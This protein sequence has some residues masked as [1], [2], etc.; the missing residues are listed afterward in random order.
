MSRITRYKQ[1]DLKNILGKRIFTNFGSR[2]TDV[3]EMHVYG[4]KTLIDSEYN[5]RYQLQA[6]DNIQTPHI[7]MDI[8]NQ[9]RNFGYTKGR[10][11]VVYNFFRNIIGEYDYP[12]GLFIKE[13]S[14]TRTE[15][16]VTSISKDSEFLNMIR[17]FTKKTPSTDRKTD[18]KGN[19]T[20]ENDISTDI[21]NG[22]LDDL[23]LNFGNNRTALV[24]NWTW[25]GEEGDGI[26]FKL[27]KP[28]DKEFQ[29]NA[30]L[31]VVKEVISSLTQPIKLVPIEEK[32]TAKGTLLPNFELNIPLKIGESGWQSWDDILGS[33]KST[34][35]SLMNSFASKSNAQAH[36][37]VDYTH[38]KN[39]VHFS[40]AVER[41][42]NFKY[43]LR[44]LE[45]YSSSLA[46][47]NAMPT[48][49]TYGNTNISEY[50]RKIEEVKNGFDGYENFMY[51]ESS[52]Y[53]SSSVHEIFPKTWP[54]TT[55]YKPYVNAKVDDTDSVTWFAS[56]SNVALDWDSV[57]NEHNLENTI[58]FHIRED[59]A[60][61]NYL[62]FTNMVAQHYDHV[63]GYLSQSL[64]IHK[65]QNPLYEGLSKDL[66]Y[67]VLASLGW[68]S[69]QGFHF[70][71]LWEYSLGLDADGAYGAESS[72][73]AIMS[74]SY[75]TAGGVIPTSASVLN[76]YA[77]PQQQSGSIS[78]E[79]MSRETW[80][81][82]L[83]NLPYLLKTKGSERG[84]KALI[85]TYGLPPTLLRIFEYG[86]PQKRKTADSFVS[87]DK[88]G[89]SLEFTGSQYLKGYHRKL[90]NHP[91]AQIGGV[92]TSRVIDSFEMRFNTWT[93]TSQSLVQWGSWPASTMN[94]GIVPHPSASNKDSGY[95]RFGAVTADF[96]GTAQGTSSYLPI[97]DNDWWNVMVSRATA[98]YNGSNH[99]HLAVAKAA[100]HSN[101]RIT[102][103][104]SIYIAN[105]EN[106][107]GSWNKQLAMYIGRS[108]HGYNSFSGSMQEIRT[109]VLPPNNQVALDEWN[110]LHAFH[111][112]ARDPQQIEGYGATGSYNQ[113]VTRWSL[114]ADL[115][116]WSGSWLQADQGERI[117]SSSAPS[118]YRRKDPF[119][120]GST[121]HIDLEPNG[122]ECDIA[123]DWPTEEEKY[124]TAMPDLVGT[125]HY[126]DKTRIE[127][128]ELVSRLDNR[129]KSERSQFDSAPLDSNRLGVYFAPNFEIDLDIARELG[130]AKFGNYVG[131][132]L[133]YRDDEYKRLR[134]LRQHYWY[135]HENPFSFHEYIKILRHLDYTLFDQI[136]RI[137]PARANAQVGLLVNC[138]MLERPKIKALYANKE[139][140]HFEGEID[141]SF[142]DILGTTTLLGGPRHQWKDPK[143]GVW[144]TGSDQ[145]GTRALNAHTGIWPSG[146]SWGS[147]EQSEGELVYAIDSRITPGGYD[148]DNGSRYIWRYMHQWKSNHTDGQGTTGH[149]K[150][151]VYYNE[152]AWIQ[153]GGASYENNYEFYTDRGDPI[154]LISDDAWNNAHLRDVQTAYPTQNQNAAFKH[155]YD[156]AKNYMPR[157]RNRWDSVHQVVANNYYP[158]FPGEPNWLT[159]DN[160]MDAGNIKNYHNQR[161]SRV[162]S[163]L[164]YYYL[165]PKNNM[166]NSGST[167]DHH[168]T[169]WRNGWQASEMADG[170]YRSGIR[171]VSRSYEPAEVQDYK[172]A[173]FR[174]L[175]YEGCKLVGSDFNMPVLATVDGGP[176]VEVTDTN[177][178]AVI[179]S[180]RS[181]N[182]GDLR[183]TGQTMARSI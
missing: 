149:T 93:P 100:D 115:N 167:G 82:M 153:Q 92:G 105:T 75:S 170:W 112:H 68:E 76:I 113:L 172:C 174:K 107:V 158:A 173:G 83:N 132:P 160:F 104:S 164:K 35:Q 122:F 99:M 72:S 15:V 131:N 125:R 178:N 57:R 23:L 53:I 157:M 180:N 39:F 175:F 143:T 5:E 63:W 14:A 3:M 163:K 155:R 4:A 25:D 16:R 121:V 29:V 26:I 62:L 165:S 77:S 101:N 90:Q 137:L 12:D 10:Y 56:Q 74:S 42:E 47:L 64:Q 19:T 84:I 6:Y 1:D 59:E 124:Y 7:S 156:Y 168:E 147:T 144:S 88:F 130:G 108:H 134:V 142:Y 67:N 126:S 171:P 96:N 2:A 49:T 151:K 41:L 154:Q 66:V 85:T 136:E 18:S 119:L 13:I 31:W 140:M 118:V 95:Y 97:Y 65:R 169:G 43:K 181:A 139:E 22:C 58:P 34:R 79:E 70:Q 61:S 102:H 11:T 54:K 37:N 89:Y 138:N 152:T 28:L 98:S 91:L 45:Q 9:I 33:N 71:D 128:A 111:N 123:V 60:N 182:D 166:G 120:A 161:L 50:E 87:Y 20:Y 38:Y 176:V 106:A 127:S 159:K 116:R 148:L 69:F 21:I 117:I 103:T 27:Y 146:S 40:S 81:R 51:Y 30:K 8:H 162:Y 46:V 17:E 94:I 48:P 177:P 150:G 145:A 114:G 32:A 129:R 141:T 73:W 135:K 80:K 133:D 179:I 44:L 109:W 78:R 24:T 55:D 110:T 52:S 183:A 86:G 36:E